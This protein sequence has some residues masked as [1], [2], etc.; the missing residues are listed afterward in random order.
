MTLDTYSSISSSFFEHF[1]V[2]ASEVLSVDRLEAA[3]LILISI[4]VLPHDYVSFE[5]S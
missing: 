2:E 4:L 1:L 5:S 3:L